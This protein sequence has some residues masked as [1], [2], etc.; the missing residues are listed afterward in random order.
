MLRRWFLHLQ[1]A[2]QFLVRLTLLALLLLPLRAC[3][4]QFAPGLSWRLIGP[5]RGGRVTAVAG[6]PGDLR[7]YYMGTPGGGIWKTTNAGATWFPIFDEAHVASIGDLKLA[8]SNPNII[9]VATGEQT[10]GNGV[11][12]S[13]DSG[14]TWTNIGIR[15]SRITPS[16]LI[17]PR[18]PNIVLVAAYGDVI[19]GESR[20]IYKTTDGGSSWRKVYFKDDQNGPI[21]LCFDPGDSRNIFAVIRHIPPVPGEK[22]A[23]GLDTFIIKSTDEGET[24]SPLGDKGL[25]ADRRGRIGLA[26]PAGLSGKRIF[27]LMNQGLFRSDDA[28]ENWQQITSDPRIIGTSYFGRVYS[29]PNNSDVVYVMQTSTYRSSDGGRTFTAWKGTPSGEDDH[30]LWIAPEDSS[31]IIMGADQGAVITLD[32]GKTWNTWYDQPTGQF[33]RVFTDHTFPYRLYAPQQDS[34]SVAV[35][36]RTDFGLNTYR[37]WFPTGAFESGFIAPDPLNP[38]FVYSIGWFGIV[39][40]LDRATG[41]VATLF[42]PP[43]TYHTVWETPLVFAPR[44]P[45]VLYYGSQFLLKTADGGKSWKEISGDLTSKPA[46]AAAPPKSSSGGHIAAKDDIEFSD[47]DADPFAQQLGRGAI[48]AIAPSPIDPNL[49]WV[50]STTGRIH[51][52]HD[53]STWIDVTPAG[54]P[55]HA[56]INSIEPSPHDADTAF[57]AIFVRRDP[58]PYLFR[59][60]NGGRSWEKIIN[61]LPGTSIGGVVREDPG[62]KGLLFAGTQTGAFFSFDMGDHWQSLQLNLPTATVTDLTIHGAD[63]VASTFGRGLWILDDISPLRQWSSDIAS[64]RVHFF[65]PETSVRVRWDNY[66]DTPLQTETPVAANPPDGAILH[67]FLKTVPKGE[68]T[69][70]VFDQQGAV[71]RHFSSKSGQETAPP[72]NVPEYW[73]SPP[74]SVPTNPGVNRFVWD[75]RYPHPT[76]LPYGY[77]GE[78][79]KYTEYDLPDHA[80]PGETPR[81][82]PPG[83]LV[84][85]GTYSLV[86]TVEGK[87]Y[88]QQ[89]QVVPDPRVHLSAADYAAQFELSR[90]ICDAMEAAARSFSSVSSLHA[91]LDA[92]KKA[93]PAKPPKELP[94]P[95]AALDKE[96]DAIETG[97]GSALGFGPLNRDLGRYLVMVQS[98]DLAPNESARNAVNAA[99]TTYGK[100]IAAWNKLNAESLPALNKLLAAQK[101]SEL[102]VA[103][104]PAAIPPCTP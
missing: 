86:L 103:S 23:E 16:L 91:E 22:P 45:H 24:W 8:P 49:I 26:V 1:V 76:A 72:A 99:C 85:P 94:D 70:D 12:K 31:R 53:G 56:F 81:F 10:P 27:A 42:V 50:G 6:V 57:A 48:Q 28:G 46:E 83:P 55:E 21:D 4:Q 13:T 69:L 66:P 100:N 92:R 59:T 74:P 75:L 25:P 60:R 34:G 97:S 98:A 71:I 32:T 87:S 19:P 104:S 58:H 37:D 52:T 9:Y 65:L 38:D 68:V 29:D 7:T 82:Q 84:A 36:S 95:L 43:T 5:F 40:R 63:L 96:L 18:N 20:G 35:P 11:W 2:V 61:G 73:F 54:L 30:V 102:P 17:D 88:R 47:D 62:R 80:V 90:K 39:V 64:S 51:V 77:F 3:P 67:Y 14:A 44:D 41:Q 15:D 101:L 89:L 79:L 78:R 93:L 33:Y